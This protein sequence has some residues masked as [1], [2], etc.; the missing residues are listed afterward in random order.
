[1]PER[2]MLEREVRQL[3]QIRADAFAL[4]SKS[5]PVAD[6]ARLR[7]QIDIRT[8]TWRGLL[9]QL[10]GVSSLDTAEPRGSRAQAKA[11]SRSKAHEGRAA[12]NLSSPAH[13]HQVIKHTQ[14]TS[15][16][17]LGDHE[18]GRL[19]QMWSLAIRNSTERACSRTLFK[20]GLKG[21]S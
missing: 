3:R 7:K 16:S 20:A 8:A 12:I 2:E 10:S 13:L 18:P 11:S 21:I 5:T 15:R 9:K 14:A 6:L 1:M 17:K 4:V 19:L